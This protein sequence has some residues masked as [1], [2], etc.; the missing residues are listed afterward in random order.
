[1]LLIARPATGS[2]RCSRRIV[3]ISRETCGLLR[4]LISARHCLVKDEDAA[5]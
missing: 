5:V 3:E 4:Y 2:W 1:M